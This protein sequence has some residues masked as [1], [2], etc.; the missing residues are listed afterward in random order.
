MSVRRTFC[1]V[2]DLCGDTLAL[3]EEQSRRVVRLWDRDD[4]T[5]SV[6]LG[7]G[8]RACLD[9]RVGVVVRDRGSSWW[10]VSPRDVASIRRRLAK[11]EA[12]R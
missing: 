8:L 11:A 4:I 10:T 1:E 2:T 6:S 12:V 9:E 3:T 5:V 7:A